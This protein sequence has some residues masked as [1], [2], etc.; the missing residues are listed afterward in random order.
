[1]SFTTRASKQV[2]VLAGLLL[3]GCAA[4]GS[5]NFFTTGA[6]GTSETTAA[7]EP[8]VDPACVSLVSRI[9]ALRKEGVAEKIEKAAAKKYKMTSADLAKA[10]QLTKANADFQLRCSTIMP[11]PMQAQVSSS[12]SAVAVAAPP[13]PAA[14]ARTPKAAANTTNSPANSEN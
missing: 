4:D 11:K 12:P 2:L 6:L 3:A 13:P 10:D 1:M 14:K 7:A 5:P 8:K 9:E